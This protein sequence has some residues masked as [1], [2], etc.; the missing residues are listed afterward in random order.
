ME[1]VARRGEVVE[2][3]RAD[4]DRRSQPGREA[5]PQPRPAA[6]DEHE[7][8]APRRGSRD[9]RYRPGRTA[10]R[11]GIDDRRCPTE[12][13]ELREPL[14]AGPPRTPIPAGARPPVRG[15]RPR[16]PRRPDRP[17]VRSPRRGAPGRR[18]GRGPGTR[19]CR[20][21]RSTRARSRSAKK[22]VV[23]RRTQ[24]LIGSPPSAHHAMP[25]SM[26]ATTAKMNWP[27]ARWPH[28]AT[29]G[30]RRTAGSGGNGMSP[31]GTPSFDGT[32]RTS[33]KKALPGESSVAST[34]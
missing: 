29:N 17:G 5:P 20:S 6:A 3:Q 28:A 33:L 19:S 14:H 24:R 9:A 32:W 21:G 13:R 25:T 26:A 15:D 12:A 31:R 1:E 34:G 30:S 4:R 10:A 2:E 27:S 8:R 23:A 7:E 11:R 16:R 18:Q 22:T